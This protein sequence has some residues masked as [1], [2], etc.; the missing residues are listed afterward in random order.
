MKYNKP[1]RVLAWLAILVIIAIL[2]F[3][4]YCSFT[5]KNFFGGLYLVIIV[6]VIIWAVLFFAGCFH[7]DDEN[8]DTKE[9]EANKN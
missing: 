5:E 2:V 3:F 9:D 8:E 7:Q 6:P 1:A 4:I